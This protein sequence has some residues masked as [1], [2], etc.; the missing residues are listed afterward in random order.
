MKPEMLRGRPGRGR[1][2][3]QVSK[4][5][6]KTRRQLFSASSADHAAAAL[7]QIELSAG[8]FDSRHQP[9]G[10]VDEANA[11]GPCSPNRALTFLASCAA[12]G[13][14]HAAGVAALD[15]EVPSVQPLLAADLFHQFL[16]A[17]S[18]SWCA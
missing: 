5:G 3:K 8:I 1:P 16:I 14:L 12:A 6:A 9:G 18:Q 2:T 10:H 17:R 4:H 7:A 11:F 15:P 13:N